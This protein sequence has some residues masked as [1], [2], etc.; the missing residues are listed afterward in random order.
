MSARGWSVKRF[1]RSNKLDTALSKNIPVPFLSGSMGP[2]FPKRGQTTIPHKSSIRP[3]RPQFQMFLHNN[4]LEAT[5][6]SILCIGRT[7]YALGV[8]S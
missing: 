5:K 3:A 8:V 1:E 7:I 2:Y 4:Q 6:V